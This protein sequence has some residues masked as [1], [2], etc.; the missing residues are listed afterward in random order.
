MIIELILLIFILYVIYLQHCLHHNQGS[1]ENILSDEP[2]PAEEKSFYQE[3]KSYYNITGIPL[4]SA[5]DEILSDNN[6]LT[7]TSL[8]FGI[9]EDYRALNVPEFLNKICSILNL[10]INHIERTKLQ[11][12]SSILEILIDGK[13][14]NIKLTLKKIYNSLTEKVKEEL[15]KL[16][17]FFMFMGDITSLI[18]KQKFRS[19]IK[20]HP[21][22]NR[23]YD[24][25]HIYWTGALQDGRDRGKFDYF[26]PI[27]WKRYAFDVNDN[28]DENGLA[29]ARC[30]ALGKGIY[31]S[32][33]IIYTSH[34]RYAEVKQI[35]SKDERN[36]F[37]NGKYVQF[38]LQ[39]R[40][41][42][43]NITVVGPE[44][45]GVGGKIAIDTNVSNDV[46]EW[47]V[48]A[49]DKDLMD[50]SDP[51]ATIVCT[52]LMIRVTDNHPGLLPE[53]QW[54]YSGHICERK[55]CCCLG[56][57]L[58][59]LIKQRNDGVKLYF[60][61][62]IYKSQPKEMSQP[63]Q[64]VTAQPKSLSGFSL[65]DDEVLL[66]EWKMPLLSCSEACGSNYVWLTN[67]RVLS[68]KEL[69][70]CCWNILPCWDQCFSDGAVYLKD[71]SALRYN[72]LCSECSIFS[73]MMGCMTPCCGSGELLGLRG[74]FNSETILFNS[75]EIKQ[76]QELISKAVSK[77]KQTK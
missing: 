5:S 29:P 41:L 51:N 30:A 18:M 35:E 7:A 25:G 20:L 56:I 65:L 22:W 17:V 44:T 54:W 11:S 40:I 21:Q 53:S 57:D 27:G 42:S 76:A 64:R 77:S 58:S 2:L 13:K 19:E 59:E 24:V 49:Q 31:A 8:K 67:T 4:I 68:R 26:C 1:P 39:C 38:V 45:L 62:R 61:H 47:V 36:F 14:V 46:I 63:V 32:Q 52:G 28:F 72:H 23:I 37:K 33:S 70:V 6:T 43:K 16:K 69:C 48:K 34:P 12:G 10:N 75:S 9:D 66:Q 15:A 3:C 74:S 71:I 50:F 60:V 55:A 73:L